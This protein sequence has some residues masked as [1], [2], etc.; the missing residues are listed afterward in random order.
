VRIRFLLALFALLVSC[1]PPEPEPG[2]FQAGRAQVRMEVPVGIGTSGS[3]GLFGGPHSPSPYVNSYPATTKLHDHPTFKAVAL[4]RGEGFEVVF[5]RVDMIAVPQQ[6]RDHVVQ[7]LGE[8]TGRDWDDALIVSATH[9]H[10]G[11]G[12]FLQGGVWHLI[13]DSFLGPHYE[14][15]I[16]GM[17]DTIQAALADLGPAELGYATPSAPDS[18]GDRR[19]E[20]GE[21]YTNDAAPTFAVWKDGRVDALVVN[22]AVHGTT[23]GLDD[24]TLSQ[25]TSGAIE[26]AIEDA[27]DHD[28][29][30]LFVNSWAG[31]VS[32]STPAQVD[33]PNLSTWPNEFDRMDSIGRYVAEQVVPAVAAATPIAEPTLLSQNVRY[34]IGRAVMPYEPGEFRFDYGGVYCESNVENCENDPPVPIDGLDE[35][36]LPF[37]EDSPAPYTSMFTVGQIGP[38]HFTTWAGEC[39]TRLAEEVMATMAGH[40]GVQDVVFFGYANDY[41]GYTLQEEDWWYGGYESSGAMWGPLQGDYMADMQGQVFA[42]WLAGEEVSWE[43][44]AA[45]PLFDGTGETWT[46]EGALAQGIVAQPP[47][48]AVISDVVT[49]AVNGSDPWLGA[50]L[51]TLQRQDGADWVDATRP[52]GQPYDSDARGFWLELTTTPPWTETTD[53]TDREFRWQF[54]MPLTRRG[55]GPAEAGGT[56]RW[57]VSVPQDGG[58]ATELFTDPV[59]VAAG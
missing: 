28:V 26:D 43:E 2:P 25:D 5:L 48:D 34:P 59:V 12:R 49:F 57:R 47:A 40:E 58:P 1:D 45:P 54:S 30:A 46:V 11:P 22:Y 42:A 4:S 23:I 35:G 24:L 3:N 10:S 21:D 52:G 15:M 32:P 36:C 39:G 29:M 55:G 50:P 51:V 53:H 6:V 8:R 38:V 14:R 16:D 18:H 17:V 9:T 19:C 56:Y 37:P 31:D 27:Y 33:T 20:D 41:L 7:R 13:A 44:P